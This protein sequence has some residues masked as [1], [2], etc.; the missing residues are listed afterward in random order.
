MKKQT[1][2][3]LSKNFYR[4]IFIIYLSLLLYLLFLSERYG[5]HI[6]SDH[7]RY[8]LEP[9]AEIKR[10]IRYRDSLSA[11]S[12]FVNITGNILAF[13]P[14]GYLLPRMS[15]KF[16]FVQTMLV[17]VFSTIAIEGL[18][19]VLRVGSFDVDDLILN[20]FGGLLGFVIYSIM[21]RK[22]RKKHAEKRHDG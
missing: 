20:T 3:K 22:R 17:V 18:Q 12:F 14:M 11:E 10:Y 4:L 7:Y 9:F 13:I 19:L 6:R 16:K 15:W 5:R 1:K 2:K 8:N 21:F